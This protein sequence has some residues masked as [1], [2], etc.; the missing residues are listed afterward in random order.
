LQG[1]SSAVET[2]LDDGVLSAEE[3]AN[4]ENFQS[5][6]SLSQDELNYDGSYTKIV[7]AAVLRDVLDGQ[8]PERVKVVDEIPFNF[9]KAERLVWLF[10]DV[11]YYEEKTKTH[12]EGGHH[13][14]SMRIAKGLYYRAGAF[15]GH[16][17]ETSQI[18]H[19]D[20]GSMGVTN[21]STSRVLGNH[22]ELSM[23]K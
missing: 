16:P 17:V 7:E 3:E 10:K 15:R 19:L 11:N 8:I 12:Y 6:F 20:I 5:F 14:F 21:I 9:Q 4:V 1:W 13:G 2:F 18:V 22:S 23:K